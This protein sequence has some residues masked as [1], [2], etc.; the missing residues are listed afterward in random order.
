MG[1]GG[2]GEGNGEHHLISPVIVFF[3]FFSEIVNLF[4]I[5][6]PI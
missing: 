4:E 1:T 6:L 3:F 5:Y 2:R